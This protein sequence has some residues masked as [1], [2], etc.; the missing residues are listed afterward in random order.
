M[1]MV[2]LFFATG[3]IIIVLTWIIIIFRS[4]RTCQQAHAWSIFLKIYAQFEIFKKFMEK[5]QEEPRHGPQIY[6]QE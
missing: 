2:S 1:C 5:A 4:T 6:V 3:N